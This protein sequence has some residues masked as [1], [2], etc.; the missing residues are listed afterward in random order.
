MVK[1]QIINKL[2][3][4]VLFLIVLHSHSGSFYHIGGFVVCWTNSLIEYK[5]RLDTSIT[6]TNIRSPLT[7]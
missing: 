5:I 3:D 1:L 4:A 6:S 2:P 7:N